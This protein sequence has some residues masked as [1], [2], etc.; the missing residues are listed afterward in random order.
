MNE[1][2]IQF[3]ERIQMKITESNQVYIELCN[4][5][6]D[7]TKENEYLKGNNLEKYKINE[8]DYDNII[9]TIC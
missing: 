8:M 6:E 3:E 4:K 7:L 1:I 2:K 9:E 5:L